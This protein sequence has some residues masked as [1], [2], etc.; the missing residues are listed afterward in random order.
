MER[1]YSD[2]WTHPQK[3][4]NWF[5]RPNR[6]VNSGDNPEMAR[7]DVT[8][9][10]FDLAPLSHRPLRSARAEPQEFAN[11]IPMPMRE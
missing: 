5:L 11:T 6:R 4:T 10:C 2:G 8:R 1:I 9:L 3:H 7:G